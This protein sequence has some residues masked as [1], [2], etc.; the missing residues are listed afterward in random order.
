MVKI[1]I[2]EGNIGAGKTTFLKRIEKKIPNCQVI[3]E[4]VSVW[5]QYTDKEGKNIL[6]YFYMDPKRYAYTFQN[7]A[8]LSRIQMLKT[9]DKSKD[10]IF[11][12]RSIFSDINVFAKNCYE[13]GLMSEIEW[14]LYK[15]FFKWSTSHLEKIDPIFIYLNCSA[16]TA[17]KRI[18]KRNRDEEKTIT[19]TYLQQLGDQHKIWF[20]NQDI[21]ELDAEKTFDEIMLEFDSIIL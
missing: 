21:I 4:P 9:I 7:I 8:F 6:E 2:I 1:Y 16:E 5:Q 13:T 14:R 10:F 18:R 11:I 15:D 12:E 20:D 3:Y 17:M 19:L